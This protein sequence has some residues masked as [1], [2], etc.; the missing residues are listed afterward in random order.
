MLRQSWCACRVSAGFNNTLCLFL[1]SSVQT[2]KSF[3]VFLGS[4]CLPPGK[5]PSIL[6]TPPWL[7]P[8]APTV[9]WVPSA[10]RRTYRSVSHTSIRYIC[11]IKVLESI[12]ANM[13]DMMATQ[14][15]TVYWWWGW[16]YLVFSIMCFILVEFNSEFNIDQNNG[17][18]FVFHN[19]AALLKVHILLCGLLENR[20]FRQKVYVVPPSTFPRA[21]VLFHSFTWH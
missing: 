15:F 3:P 21:S 4:A 12:T 7:C 10:Q 1:L 8:K 14:C 5:T 20:F 13:L 9:C 6:C 17:D 16:D 18:W 11:E 19:W 2:P